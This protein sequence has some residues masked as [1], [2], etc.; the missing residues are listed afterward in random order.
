M[1]K[2]QEDLVALDME[3]VLLKQLVAHLRAWH[4]GAQQPPATH[5][6]RNLAQA[7]TAHGGIGWHTFLAGE[8]GTSI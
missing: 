5:F 2:L 6:R 4:S 1:E 3:P 7:L 8:G